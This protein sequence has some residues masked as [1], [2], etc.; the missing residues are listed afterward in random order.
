MPS[1]R[2]VGG[3]TQVPNPHPQLLA[4]RME[5]LEAFLTHPAGLKNVPTTMSEK[6][7]GSGQV[8]RVRTVDFV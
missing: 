4:E 8:L 1:G 2:E 6:N 5:G 7:C 3:G